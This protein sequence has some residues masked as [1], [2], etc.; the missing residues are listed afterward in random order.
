[1]WVL[2]V[3]GWVGVVIAGSAL[4]WVAINR[5]GDQVNGGS[6]QSTTEPAVVTTLGTAPAGTPV[7]SRTPSP[8]API[9]TAPGSPRSTPTSSATT[10]RPSVRPTAKGS[11]SPSVRAERRT[12]TGAAGFVT[13]S[14]T[15][16]QARLEGASPSDGW[17]YEVGDAAGDSVEVKFE[18]GESEVQVHAA[19]VGAVPRF[20]V[21][22]GGE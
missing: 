22:S 19:C 4:T 5:A 13:V 18:K 8:G 12:W 3:G 6:G 1:M 21:E 14:C 2:A 7:P 11:S 10:T 20:E 16:R 9:A 15:G 17:S